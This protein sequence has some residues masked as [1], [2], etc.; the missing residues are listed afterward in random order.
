MSWINLISFDLVYGGVWL[1]RTKGTRKVDLTLCTAN[2][3]PTISQAT[4]STFFLQ[5]KLLRKTKTALKKLQKEMKETLPSQI[6]DAS[7]RAHSGPRNHSWFDVGKP[8]LMLFNL[9]NKNLLQCVEHDTGNPR[10][11]SSNPV[12]GIACETKVISSSNCNIW[13]C[14]NMFIEGLYWGVCS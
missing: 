7:R 6:V 3:T 8:D 12:S 14:E 13:S 1:Y 4:C 2:G 5:G 11:L 10:V 9:L